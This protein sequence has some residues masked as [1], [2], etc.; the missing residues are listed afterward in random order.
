ML[1]RLGGS[2][3]ASRNARQV[4]GREIR[5]LVEQVRVD[6]DGIGGDDLSELASA[7][8]GP[9]WGLILQSR[10]LSED[11]LGFDAG[12]VP[13]S[14]MSARGLGEV[15]VVGPEL[16]AVATHGCGQVQGVR[17]LEA[18]IDAKLACEVEQWAIECHHLAAL[19]VGV[20]DREQVLAQIPKGLESGFHPNELTADDLL[21]REQ[22]H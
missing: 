4:F 2:L 6:L 22:R 20:V 7:N 8:W 1:T 18:V 21:A 12:P 3:P 10:T 11:R 5:H 16:V 15:V 13:D 17:G 14:E 9:N 19:K